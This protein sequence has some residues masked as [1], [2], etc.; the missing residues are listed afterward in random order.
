MNKELTEKCDELAGEYAYSLHP[1]TSPQLKAGLGY[2]PCVA[3]YKA[4]FNAAHDLLSKELEEAEKK[5][6]MHSCALMYAGGKIKLAELE[7]KELHSELAEAKE[8]ALVEQVEVESFTADM[9]VERDAQLKELK[10]ENEELKSRVNKV[11]V[12]EALIK[13]TSNTS[14]KLRLD[15]ATATSALEE[16]IDEISRDYSFVGVTAKEA[17]AKITKAKDG[18]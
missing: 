5:I 3:D 13:R 8:M 17:L 18:K 10:K 16:T 4:G 2:V 6:D 7:T 9:I 14:D 11:E 12:L 15:L 1:R